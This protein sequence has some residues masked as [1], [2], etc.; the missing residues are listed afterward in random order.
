MYKI[1]VEITALLSLVSY[2]YAGV[3]CFFSWTRKNL[4]TPI[5]IAFTTCIPSGY[6]RSIVPAGVSISE[7][8]IV[9]VY[10]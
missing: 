1:N 2:P 6:T 5:R 10:D 3:S 9:Y 4:I 7:Q 8:K